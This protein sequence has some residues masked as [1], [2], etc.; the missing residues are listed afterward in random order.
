LRAGG[1]SIPGGCHDWRPTLPSH[2]ELPPH[3]TGEREATSPP[4]AI[5]WAVG[6]SI[7]RVD[8]PRLCGQLLALLQVSDAAVVVCDVGAVTDPDAVTVEALARLQLTALR[9]GRR[10]HLDGACDRLWDLLAL[11]GLRD[12]L[13][14]REELRL[15]PRRQAEQRE[16]PLGVEEEGEPT[17]PA[18]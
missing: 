1:G 14:P 17:D 12:V 11:T 9:R 4:G 2:D 5:V 15:Q 7:R 13:A 18:G 8:I 16:Q 3:S 10:I 6:P